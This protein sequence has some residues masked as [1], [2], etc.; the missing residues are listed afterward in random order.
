MVYRHW[1]RLFH[2][3]FTVGMLNANIGTRRPGSEAYIANAVP[4]MTVDVS[5][6]LWY[7]RDDWCLVSTWV[8]LFRPSSSRGILTARPTNT[9]GERRFNEIMPDQYFPLWR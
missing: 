3:G 6:Y 8:H 5:S 4:D 2:R 9:T 7:R 1:D